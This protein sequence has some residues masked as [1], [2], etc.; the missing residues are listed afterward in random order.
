M[1][2][3]DKICVMCVAAFCLVVLNSCHNFLLDLT[4]PEGNKIVSF[5]VE[6]Q[7][8][9]ANI[10]EQGA[11]V[12]PITWD[13]LKKAFPSAKPE[14]LLKE[15]FLA[16]NVSEGDKNLRLSIRLTLR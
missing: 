11:T 2:T 16:K 9:N 5:T 12:I 8:Q 13:Y 14:Q 10:T 7:I 3:K 15:Y 1:K 4:P 6:G